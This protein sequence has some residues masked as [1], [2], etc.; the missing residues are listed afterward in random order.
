MVDDLDGDHDDEILYVR[1]WDF[2][3]CYLLCGGSLVNAL[4]G[5]WSGNF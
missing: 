2:F 3:S 1:C 4:V 5:G